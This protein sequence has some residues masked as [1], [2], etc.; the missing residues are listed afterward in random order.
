M[1]ALRRRVR[2][3]RPWRDRA[4]LGA[5]SQQLYHTLHSLRPINN[6][7]SY[8]DITWNNELTVLAN[9]RVIKLSSVIYFGRS[10]RACLIWV[11]TLPL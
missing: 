2:E 9:G 5:T 8:K 3:K 4:S 1:S 6:I 10:L 7:T 11:P